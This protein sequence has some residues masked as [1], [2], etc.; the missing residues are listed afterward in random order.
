MEYLSLLSMCNQLLL[1]AAQL[2]GTYHKRRVLSRAIGSHALL[3][4]KDSKVRMPVMT[5][6][7]GYSGD[8]PTSILTG[9]PM[10]VC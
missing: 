1:E 5:L 3:T 2:A 4:Y 7:G 6:V 9:P 10:R 8:G